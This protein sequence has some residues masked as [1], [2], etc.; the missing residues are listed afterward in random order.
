MLRIRLIYSVLNDALRIVKR[1]L[2]PFVQLQRTS[3]AATWGIQ[4]SCGYPAGWASP[5]RSCTLFGK[6][7]H[8][9]SEPYS[10]W[11]PYTR[12]E[13]LKSRRLLMTAVR[14]LLHDLFTLYS[15]LAERSGQTTNGPRSICSIVTQVS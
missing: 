12:E 10:S 5:L 6:S 1:C 11:S 2:R 15:I 4:P 8:L 3:Y 13:R 7:W 9:E 14:K